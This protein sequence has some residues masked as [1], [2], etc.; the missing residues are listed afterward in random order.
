MYW[1]AGNYSNSKIEMASMDGRNRT[2]LHDTNLT[3]IYALTIDYQRQVLYWT[4]GDMLECSNVDG[5]NRR[6]L[7]HNYNFG[8]STTL[9]LLDHTIFVYSYDASYGCYTMKIFDI[10]TGNVT[11]IYYERFGGSSLSDF[12]VV[13]D[14]N[15]PSGEVE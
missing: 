13:S 5:S 10:D 1:T 12:A 9:S 8:S 14:L 7:A 2:V 15:Q 3:S 11:E 6:V 4:N